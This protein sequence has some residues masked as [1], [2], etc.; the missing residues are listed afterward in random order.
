MVDRL[1]HWHVTTRVVRYSS[2][3]LQ[4]RGVLI[5]SLEKLCFHGGKMSEVNSSFSGTTPIIIIDIILLST[6]GSPSESHIPNDDK[7]GQMSS[8]ISFRDGKCVRLL[9]CQHNYAY[10]MFTRMSWMHKVTPFYCLAMLLR[11]QWH[12]DDCLRT[13]T[14]KDLRFWSPFWFLASNFI[15]VNSG[16][17]FIEAQEVFHEINCQ[18][19]SIRS[20]CVIMCMRLKPYTL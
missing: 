13:I 11:R 4:S 12:R 9:L 1:L 8:R 19:A 6:E 18:P 5:T 15:P 7:R 17:T 14:V 2:E 16:D 3:D 10:N 20:I